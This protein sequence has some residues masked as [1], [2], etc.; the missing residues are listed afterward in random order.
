[1]AV[2]RKTEHMLRHTQFTYYAKNERSGKR[3]FVVLTSDLHIKRKF[4]KR[5]P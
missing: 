1:M 2:A 4:E 5:I 3:V